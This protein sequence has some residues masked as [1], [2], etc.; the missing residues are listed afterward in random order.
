MKFKI[1]RAVYE[2]GMSE[3]GPC[4]DLH[5]S[6]GKTIRV[7]N[8][9]VTLVESPEG[10]V[11]SKSP[12]S[13]VDEVVDREIQSFTLKRGADGLPRYEDSTGEMYSMDMDA[14]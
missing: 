12:I 13:D 2:D 14:E 11:R 1:I 6:N 4:V 5:F 9:T 7:Y 3:E 8:G 10:I